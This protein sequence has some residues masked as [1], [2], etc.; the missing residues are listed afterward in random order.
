MRTPRRARRVLGYTVVPATILATGI[1]VS[2]SS[3]SVFNSQTLN[4][5]N[6]W[7]T[8]TVALQSDGSGAGGASGTAM[9]AADVSPGST[10]TRCITV[11]SDGT[12]PSVV[13]LYGANEGATNGL[14]D[15]LTLTVRVGTA[16]STTGGA[17]TGFTSTGTVF[18][19]GRLSTF[20]T[21]GYGNGLGTTWSPTG[22]GSES[23]VFQF[24]YTMDTA[25]PS[26]TQAGTAHI[27]F[28]WE[29]QTS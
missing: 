16:S 7:S 10:G 12:V 5:G 29:A 6:N 28:V 4:S 21:G 24:Q 8:G 11:T 22:S 18:S 17:C 23:R 26:S 2:A 14:D 15:Y 1:F 20:P 13:K 27:D 19:A 9:F 3:Y 25:A